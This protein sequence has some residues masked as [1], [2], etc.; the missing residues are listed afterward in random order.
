MVEHRGFLSSI[1]FLIERILRKIFLKKDFKVQEN[2]GLADEYL[3]PLE[4]F[5]DFEEFHKILRSN[6]LEII[7]I[8]DGMSNDLEE[9]SLGSSFHP[10][11]RKLSNTQTYRLIELLDKPRGVGFLCRK[12]D[13]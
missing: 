9:L 8:I 5:Y 4:N 7:E 6:E 11:I 12:I 1:H 3:N 10:K 13:L 2:I